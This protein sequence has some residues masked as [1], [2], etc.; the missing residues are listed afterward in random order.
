MF[1]G[2]RC[3]NIAVGWGVVA[4]LLLV[5]CFTP[6]VSASGKPSGSVYRDPYYQQR[7]GKEREAREWLSA[8]KNYPPRDAYEPRCDKDS[9]RDECLLAWRATRAAEIQ[10]RAAVDQAYWSQA[11]VWFLVFTFGATAVAAYFA[12]KA[13]AA[14]HMGAV[15]D[16][17]SA[18]TADK[19]LKEMQRTAKRQLRAYIFVD[20][21]RVLDLPDHTKARVKLIFKNAGQTPAYDV[22]HNMGRVTRSVGDTSAFPIRTESDLT[23]TKTIINPGGAFKMESALNYSATQIAA[24]RDGAKYELFVFGLIRYVDAFEDVQTARYRAKLDPESGQL[25]FCEEG[26]EAT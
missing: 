3:S 6:E 17:A 12:Y 15:A 20:E 10:A 26:N 8:P 21:A 1:S 14:T 9:N 7:Q 22:M 19:T 2:Y 11:S 25:A 13:A 24:V 23:G 16:Q 5:L 18:A 4:S